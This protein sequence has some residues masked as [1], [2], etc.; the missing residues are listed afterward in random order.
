[1]IG[2]ALDCGGTFFLLVTPTS[3]NPD[4]TRLRLAMFPEKKARRFPARVSP[5]SHVLHRNHLVVLTATKAR[6]PG[7][8]VGV[9]PEIDVRT[10]KHKRS[11]GRTAVKARGRGKSRFDRACGMFTRPCCGRRGT[12]SPAVGVCF[13]GYTV[14][15]SGLADRCRRQDVI[16]RCIGQT[17]HGDYTSEFPTRRVRLVPTDRKPFPCR[18]FSVWIYSICL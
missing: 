13:Q 17:N 12:G 9:S 16:R 11:R 8:V 2:H 7:D 1:M 18:C 14:R 3:P 10:V 15:R 6:L 4:N 5:A